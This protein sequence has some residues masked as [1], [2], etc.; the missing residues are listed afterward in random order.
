MIKVLHVLNAAPQIGGLELSFARLAPALLECGVQSTALLIGSD[1]G[2]AEVL[3][4]HLP[5]LRTQD[6]GLIVDALQ[7]ADVVHMHGASCTAWPRAVPRLAKR[8]R[9]PLV[10]TI[11]LPRYPPIGTWS[12]GRVR[13]SA[14]L[15][16]YGVYLARTTTRVV[17]PSDAAAAMA[18]RRFGP[19]LR[20]SRFLYGAPD[21]G[22]SAVPQGPLRLAFVGRLDPHKQPLVFVESVAAAVAQGV[23]VHAEMAG[24]GSQADEVR[25]LISAKG[26]ED[27]ITLLGR[28]EHPDPLLRRSHVLVFT[29]D[30]EGCPVSAIEAA[31]VGRGVICR[32]GI[33]GLTELWGVG[34]ILVAPEGG[35]DEFAAAYETV[36]SDLSRAA[37]MGEAA[38]HLFQ[39][40]FDDR[41]AAGRWAALYG[42]ATA[43]P[44]LR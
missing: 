17:A 29:S 12:P 36:A 33:E 28:I 20:V 22:A 10:F 43:K 24:D 23:D 14:Q 3:A 13:V 21:H 30:A 40:E 35:A 27:R 34:S 2:S 1:E 31:A 5:V 26:L 18:R 4:K 19:W 6:R 7:K 38:R 8:A 42:E 32:A 25:A 41:V 39:A 11:H 37:L 16:A 15:L 44:A 9:R